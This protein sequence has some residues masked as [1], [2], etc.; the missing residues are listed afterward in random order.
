MDLERIR[1]LQRKPQRISFTLPHAVAE[2]LFKTATN[3][4]RSVSNLVAYLIE[5]A[6]RRDLAKQDDREDQR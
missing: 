4:G 3:Q 1:A 5:L 6:M 2:W